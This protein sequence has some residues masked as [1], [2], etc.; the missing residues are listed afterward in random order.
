[1]LCVYVCV[2]CLVAGWSS[3][4]GV[5]HILNSEPPEHY[6]NPVKRWHFAEQ[7]ITHV[8]ILSGLE[9]R[10]LWFLLS[11]SFCLPK[12]KLLF[13][14]GD[15]QP[16]SIILKKSLILRLYRF[17]RKMQITFNGCLTLLINWNCW[18]TWEF[19]CL[20]TCVL[21]IVTSIIACPYFLEHI[22]WKKSFHEFLSFFFFRTF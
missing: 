14:H 5:F 2:S 17:H 20:Y 1:M 12:I 6:H 11:V 16:V 8:R 3:L 9:V 10:L 22:G 4:A 18:L 13:L 21:K 15:S 19:I 7:L